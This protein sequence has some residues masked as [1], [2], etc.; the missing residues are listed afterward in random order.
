MVPALPG[1]P[2]A[3]AASAESLDVGREVYQQIERLHL[4]GRWRVAVGRAFPGAYGAARSYEEAR[5]A[6]ALAH[7]LDLD[8]AVVDARDP[9]STA[10]WGRD[11]AAMLSVVR[12]VLAPLEDA[13]R[14]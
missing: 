2:N 13:G 1:R 6:L 10:C 9:P 8:A 7:R 12:D 4:A 11:Q 14:C 5:E 3:G